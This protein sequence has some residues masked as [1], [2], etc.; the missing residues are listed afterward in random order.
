MAESSRLRN[1]RRVFVDRPEGLKS[2]V[3]SLME[4]DAIG[5]DV[6]MGQRIERLPGGVTKGKQLLALI[7]LAGDDL[8]VAI[9]PTRVRDLEALEPL[10]VAPI[11]KVVLGGAT[12]VELLFERGLNVRTVADLAEMAISVF[13]HKQEGMRALADRALGVHVDKS[14][15]REDWLRRPVDPAMLNYAHRDAE[16]TLL[17]Y[18]WFQSE[19]PD[20]IKGHVRSQ[21]TPTPP[22]GVPGWIQKCLMKRIDPVRFLKE[23]GVDVEGE[24]AQLLQDIRIARA[25]ELTPAQERRVVRLIGELRLSALY[26]DVVPYAESPSSVFRSTAARALGKLANEAARPIL[27]RLLEDQIPDVRTAAQ[28]GLRDLNAGPPKTSLNDD[29]GAPAGLKPEAL[30]A[31]QRLRGALSRPAHET[32]G[33]R[34]QEEPK[35]MRDSA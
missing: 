17:L 8:S 19:H 23:E 13:G 27:H 18:R 30:A 1:F 12:D 24:V 14:I 34:S 10:M 3:E 32:A 2:V 29:E 20:L 33:V 31:L 9:D 22:P 5:L 15:R 6:E 16:L 4:T 21:L 7:Q 25:Q 26:P 28:V 35:G 11:V